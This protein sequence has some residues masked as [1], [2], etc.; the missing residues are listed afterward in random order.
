MAK[1][2]QSTLPRGE[3]LVC[4]VHRVFDVR[5]QSTLPRGERLIMNES[6]C[7]RNLFQSTLPRGE[8][9][10]ETISWRLP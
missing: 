10:S 4:C 7:C 2:F 8:R 9:R 1:E 3:R 6:G 5:F